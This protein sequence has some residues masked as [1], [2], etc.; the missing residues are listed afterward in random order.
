MKVTWLDDKQTECIVT[1]G[2]FRWRKQ[3]RVHRDASRGCWVYTLTND[4]VPGEVRRVVDDA[5]W[6]ERLRR[7]EATVEMTE[8]L[9]WVPLKETNMPHAR[10]HTE[11]ASA[12]KLLT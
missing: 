6:R 9:V 5:A 8:R 7:A 2:W 10:I 12:R 1:R 11:S 4:L 3:A